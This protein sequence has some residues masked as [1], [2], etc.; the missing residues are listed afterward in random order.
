MNTIRHEAPRQP[1]RSGGWPEQPN[2]KDT[3]H[4]GRQ[5]CATAHPSV[6]LG[7]RTAHALSLGLGRMAIPSWKS[8]SKQAWAA[9]CGRATCGQ[10]VQAVGPRT[11]DLR[12]VVVGIRFLS[13]L[14]VLAWPIGY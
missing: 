12:L 10:Y 2:R 11:S 3:T 8:A 1:G 14:A 7:R 5:T 13:V 9:P 6:S 4:H